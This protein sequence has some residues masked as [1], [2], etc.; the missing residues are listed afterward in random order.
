[1]RSVTGLLLGGRGV[2]NAAKAALGLIMSLAAAASAEETAPAAPALAPDERWEFSFAPYIW[3]AGLDGT[4]SADNHSADVDVSFSD[5]LDDLD[6]GFLAAAEARRGR[7]AFAANL[8]YLKLSPDASQPVGALLPNAPPGDLDVRNTTE[9]L[10]FELRPTYEVLS[11]PLLGDDAPQRIA[12]DLGPGARIW[13]LKTH[14]DVKLDPGSPL[15]PFQQRFDE[16]LDWVDFVAAA[17]VRVRLSEKLG[18]VVAGDYGGWDIGSSSHRT[19][20]ALGLLSYSLGESWDLA[21][22]W[23]TLNIDRGPADL[24]MAGPLLGAAYRF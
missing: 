6:A 17:R 13:R 2:R 24:D 5:I 16:K 1:M 20:S 12:L 3:A 18:L 21:A 7:F 22:G 4:V 23:R 14:L 9:Q 11:L 10:I 19:W 15:G 8:V